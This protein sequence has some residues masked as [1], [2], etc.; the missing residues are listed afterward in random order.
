M[1]AR[2]MVAGY[3]L[4]LAFGV[5]DL[6]AI[7]ELV[8]DLVAELDCFVLVFAVCEPLAYAM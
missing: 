1:P 2:M 5:V 7:R 6:L 8:D 3:C 4:L